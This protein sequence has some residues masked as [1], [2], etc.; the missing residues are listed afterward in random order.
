MLGFSN[1]NSTFGPLPFNLA[2]FG[3]PG[4]FGRVSPD[5]TSLLLGSNN[6]A[7]W[8]RGIPANARLLATP[9]FQQALVLDPTANTF[10]GVVSDAIA[11]IVGN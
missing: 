5:A 10:G 3:A 2:S 1:T 7:T 6:A 8:S 4:G 11:G 9:L